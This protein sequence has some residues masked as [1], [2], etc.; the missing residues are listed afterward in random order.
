VVDRLHGSSTTLPGER[1]DEVDHLAWPVEGKEV[2]AAQN[3]AS[4]FLFASC[5]TPETE[6]ECPNR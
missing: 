1:D 6:R 2:T 4:P 5:G 3:S